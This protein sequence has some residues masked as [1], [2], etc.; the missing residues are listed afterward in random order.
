MVDAGSSLCLCQFMTGNMKT[1]LRRNIIF[2]SLAFVYIFCI[3]R[4]FYLN[5]LS[6]ILEQTLHIQQDLGHGGNR[7]NSSPGPPVESETS[8]SHP[9]RVSSGAVTEDFP[10]ALT[11]PS[12]HLAYADHLRG[13]GSPDAQREQTKRFLKS[14]LKNQKY[15]QVS[16]NYNYPSSQSFPAA[17]QPS[18]ATGVQIP[19]F[20]AMH[21][22]SIEADRWR[23]TTHNPEHGPHLDPSLTPRHG[24]SKDLNVEA[25]LAMR[26]STA[27]PHTIAPHLAY[28]DEKVQFIKDGFQAVR[29]VLLRN[30]NLINDIDEFLDSSRKQDQ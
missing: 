9:L 16:R 13:Q 6:D 19:S 27:V 14:S 29:Q 20:P 5:F 7:S 21:Q 2:F 25:S 26:S 15:Q 12:T 22:Y 23:D 1:L 8:S 24:L 28:S 11:N 4:L 30:S 10:Q 17:P 18:V 3:Q